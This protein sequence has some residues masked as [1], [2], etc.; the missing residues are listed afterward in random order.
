MIWFANFQINNNPEHAD[1][2]FGYVENDKDIGFYF[3]SIE[4][5]FNR[6]LKK[7]NDTT[8]TIYFENLTYDGEFILWWAL[9]KKLKPI[10]NGRVQN[11]QIKEKNEFNGKKIEMY[12]IYKGVR[13][14]LLCSRKIFN[15]SIKL[16][17]NL[18]NYDINNKIL[19]TKKEWTNIDEIPAEFKNEVRE[20]VKILKDKYIEFKT[21]YEIRKTASSSSWNNFKKWYFKTYSEDDWKKR[22][23]WFKEQY[24][25]FS[26]FFFGGFNSFNKKYQNIEINDDILK[27]DI[28][29]SYCSIVS[30]FNLPY[31]KPS[32]NKPD[33]DYVYF[34]KAKI[35]NIRKKDLKMPDH[36]HNKSLSY[37]HPE[38]YISNYDDLLEVGYTDL[39]WNEIKKTYDFDIFEIKKLYFKADKKLKPYID[40]IYELKNNENDPS[41]KFN[42]KLMLNSFTGKWGQCYNKESLYLKENENGKYENYDYRK[43][44]EIEFEIKYNPVAIFIT[45]YARV[46]LLKKIREHADYWINSDTDSIIIFKNRINDFK[47]SDKIGDWKI[48]QEIT[49]FKILKNKFYIYQNK[50]NEM[51]QCLSGIHK[52]KH[53]LYDF[54]NFY[55]G[56]IIKNGNLRVQKVNGGIYF[57]EIDIKL[58]E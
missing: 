20:K 35:Y 1:I 43:K 28:N 38:T 11:G 15:L 41:I 12:F 51:F 10:K 34:V 16:M 47:I 53:K 30:K 44:T 25:E 39:E 26:K 58:G 2:Y 4:N 29:S 31:G 14:D 50:E 23:L 54:S 37:E 36:L 57:K 8:H 22:Y 56:K 18:K 49:K 3:K 33:G 21:Y 7:S 24:D 17:G 32:L 19:K 52:D 42:H 27:L 9:K 48:E 46:N 40:A 5:L 45:S 55:F 13:F 6:I